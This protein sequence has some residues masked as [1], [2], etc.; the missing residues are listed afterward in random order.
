M[1]LEK[2]RTLS[3]LVKKLQGEGAVSYCIKM[4]RHF[5]NDNPKAL[6]VWEG[7]LELLLIERGDKSSPLGVGKPNGKG[8]DGYR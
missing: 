8:T 4:I 6:A 7:V 1:P 3:E 2:F 5:R